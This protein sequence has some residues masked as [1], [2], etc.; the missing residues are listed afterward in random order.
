MNISASD[1][2]D[3]HLE[4]I[5]KIDSL[6]LLDLDATKITGQRLF[7]LEP[8]KNLKQLRLKDNPQL[9]DMCI[10][11]LLN[12]QSLELIHIGNTSITTVG[13]RVLLVYDNKVLLVSIHIKIYTFFRNERSNLVKQCK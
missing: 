7:Y 3:K 12:I 13:A 6:G 8:L 5:E 9:T 4:A 1:L 11:Y 2:I 10:E